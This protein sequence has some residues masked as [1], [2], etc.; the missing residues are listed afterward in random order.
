M[1]AAFSCNLLLD[2]LSLES[3][4]L[5]DWGATGLLMAAGIMQCQYIVHLCHLCR[6]P[7]QKCP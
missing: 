6:Q 7:I 1:G 5:A 3:D 2:S 4:I